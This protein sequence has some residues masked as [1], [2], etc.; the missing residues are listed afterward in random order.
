LTMV[1]SSK[2]PALKTFFPGYDFDSRQMVPPQLSQ[3]KLEICSPLSA[4]LVYFLGVPES[5]LKSSSGMRKFMLNAPPVILRQSR[6][7]QRTFSLGSAVQETRMFPQ[8]QPASGILILIGY[9]VVLLV[10]LSVDV[11]LF[12]I[13][14]QEPMRD[15]VVLYFIFAVESVVGL[16]FQS[17]KW[18]PTSMRPAFAPLMPTMIQYRLVHNEFEST[19]VF[20][21]RSG[22]ETVRTRVGIGDPECSYGGMTSLV[23]YIKKWGISSASTWMFCY[24][25]ARASASRKQDVSV[26]IISWS[27]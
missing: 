10:S 4:V 5:N 7:W 9:R 11:V 2:V 15:S 17:L 3:K 6:Q 22:N 24:A 20:H 8:R 27:L 26:I 14:E 18:Q 19:P 25:R 16:W 13:N 1:A 12:G 21:W 23:P